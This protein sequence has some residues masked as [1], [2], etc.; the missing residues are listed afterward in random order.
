MS[1]LGNALIG[2][3]S[4]TLAILSSSPGREGGHSWHCAPLPWERGDAGGEQLLFLLSA[5]HLFSDFLLQKCAGTSLLDSY[6]PT[7]VLSSVGGC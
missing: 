5:M 4:R 7:K 1:L 2:W 3:G 6:T